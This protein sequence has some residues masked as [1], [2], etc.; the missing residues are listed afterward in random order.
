[1]V[2]GNT[3]ILE[4]ACGR[5]KLA[6]VEPIYFMVRKWLLQLI[7]SIT[8]RRSYFNPVFLF[9]CLCWYFQSMTC[10]GGIWAIFLHK[11]WK[12]LSIFNHVAE[13]M[14]KRQVE[15]KWLH[16]RNTIV[17]VLERWQLVLDMKLFTWV[18]LRI[19]SSPF[20][21]QVWKIIALVSEKNSER[22]PFQRYVS[23]WN[24]QKVLLCT[25]PTSEAHW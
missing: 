20:K 18:F 11:S 13:V 3:L 12:Y 25:S 24:L 5:K 4:V 9:R 8:K 17:V 6:F 21:N 2:A 14:A 7:R 22:F 1:M 16:F 15:M 19:G 10:C 23:Q